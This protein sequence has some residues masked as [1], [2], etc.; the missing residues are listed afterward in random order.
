MQNDPY[1]SQDSLIV[2]KAD[3]ATE[4]LTAAKQHLVAEQEKE[5]AMTGL[6]KLSRQAA[7]IT[8]AKLDPEI[9]KNETAQGHTPTCTKRDYLGQTLYLDDQIYQLGSLLYREEHAADFLQYLHYLTLHQSSA[10]G[11]LHLL[12]SRKVK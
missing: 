3:T 12:G 2:F 7:L 9:T 11:I 1:F 6:E 10:V 5:T 8:A 4:H